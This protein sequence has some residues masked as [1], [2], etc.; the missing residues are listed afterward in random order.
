MDDFYDMNEPIDD[1]PIGPGL[2]VPLPVPEY[3]PEPEKVYTVTLSDGAELTGLHLSGN[4][5]VSDVPVEK[6]LFEF[7][8]SPVS[9]SDGTVTEKHENMELNHLQIIDGKWYFVLLDV[10][11]EE[12]WKRKVTADMQYMSM[13]TEVELD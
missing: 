3:E 1:E 5:F 13:M 4:N 11:P 8:C 7:N 10:P 12:L 6:E 9:V 2:Y